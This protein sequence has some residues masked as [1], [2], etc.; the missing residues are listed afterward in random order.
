MQAPESDLPPS[1]PSSNTAAAP[2]TG[3]TSPA[4]VPPEPT[5]TTVATSPAIAGP[6]H[7]KI[8]CVKPAKGRK[9]VC[10]ELVSIAADPIPSNERERD[11]DE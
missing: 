3:A 6:P 1:P 5:S 10:G 4:P 7:P 11:R 8:A 9:V 2:T